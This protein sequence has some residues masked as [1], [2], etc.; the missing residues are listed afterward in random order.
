MKSILRFL[1]ISPI[2]KYFE[3]QKTDGEWV[4][5]NTREAP[6]Q[7]AP[8]KVFE[9]KRDRIDIPA[10][11]VHTIDEGIS[12]VY[13]QNEAISLL[14]TA[15]RRRSEDKRH[16]TVLVG[17]G[18]NSGRTTLAKELAETHEGVLVSLGNYSIGEEAC[19]RSFGD[20][21]SIGHGGKRGSMDSND[22]EAL[23]FPVL[24][25][26]VW[27]LSRGMKTEVPTFDHAT[28]ERM[29]F[30][31]KTGERVEAFKDTSKYGEIMPPKK[32]GD[33]MAI[34]DKATGN[35]EERTRTVEPAKVTV[36]EGFHALDDAIAPI[37]NF[38]VFVRTPPEGGVFRR[39][40]RYPAVEA[41][42][43]KEREGALLSEALRVSLE[44]QLNII[45]P[46][47]YNQIDLTSRNADLIIE[48]GYD[49][50]KGSNHIGNREVQVKYR[51]TFDADKLD[52]IGAEKVYS[53]TQ[54]DYYLTSTN[55]EEAIRIREDS[56]TLRLIY[57]GPADATGE[58]DRF[59]CEIDSP[60]RDKLFVLYPVRETITKNRTLYKFKE[61]SVST[62]EVERE[63]NGIVT[64]LGNF[65]EIKTR[66]KNEIDSRNLLV[67]RLGLEDAP[68]ITEAYSEL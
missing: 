7:E 4:T 17:G 35:Y 46:I 53:V 18:P 30:D 54:K 23:D 59:E 48:N 29:L 49:P 3:G 34:S 51:G 28:G 11:V 67:L 64:H 43:K 24:L 36:V 41:A 16:T 13:S 21:Y 56:G 20:G 31:P 62:D 42:A 38:N 66:N 1:L 26:N 2:V 22:R 63:R 25:M 58:R 40:M 65:I 9:S 68:Q 60:T 14:N 37:G 57:M 8:S 19:K 45:L 61:I 15:I 27:D 52:E 50:H 5:V 6:R 32:I 44:H 10:S 33:N 39:V 47:Y 55:A 12:V